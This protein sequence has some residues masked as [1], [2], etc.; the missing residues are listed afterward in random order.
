MKTRQEIY[1]IVFKKYRM[2]LGHEYTEDKKNRLSNI[3]AVQNTERIY[4]S[5]FDSD[6][7]VLFMLSFLYR[8]Y[9]EKDA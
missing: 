3:Y 5:Q 9:N 1:D 7:N 4:Q 8:I 2:W 6:N